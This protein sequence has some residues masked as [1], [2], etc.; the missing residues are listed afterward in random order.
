MQAILNGRGILTGELELVGRIEFRLQLDR[1]D[2]WSAQAEYID[3]HSVLPAGRGLNL[4]TAGQGIGV[5]LERDHGLDRGGVG[6][7]G[8]DAASYK[9][10]RIDRKSVV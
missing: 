10:G 9:A 5:V 7:H 4:E 2:G 8:D 6:G 1:L 3:T